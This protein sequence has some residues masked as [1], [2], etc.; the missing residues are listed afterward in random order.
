MNNKNMTQMYSTFGDKLLQHTDILYSIQYK[1]I[2]KP[3]T[4]QLCPTEVCDLNCNYCSVANRDKN[5]SIDIDSIIFGL[6][7]FKE[8]GAKSLEISG[9]GN[10]LLYPYINYVIAFA[11]SLGYEI[12]IITNSPNPSKYLS[13][14]SINC[15]SWIRVSLSCLDFNLTNVDFDYIPSEKLGLSYIINDKT[16]ESTISLIS[17]IA[18]KYNVKFVRLA[19]DCLN[20]DSLTISDKWQNIIDKYNTDGKLFLKEINDN[21]YPYSHGCYVGLIRPY[22]N[23]NGVYICSS[24]VL[25]TRRCEDDWKMCSINNIKDFYDKCN[26]NL[27]NKLPPYHIDIDKCYHCY[28]YNNNKILHTIITELPDRNFA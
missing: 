19:P 9:G 4:V 18:H 16:S 8:L 17:N 5:K 15:L 6:T 22:W 25:K 7:R 12:G 13:K 28:Y 20:D 1:K 23:Y 3:I 10:P 2:F 27:I 14:S 24:H 26:S 11:Y 21:F